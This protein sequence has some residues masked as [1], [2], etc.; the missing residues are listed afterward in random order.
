MK[1]KNSCNLVCKNVVL[2]L[3]FMHRI[4]CSHVGEALD[5]KMYETISIEPFYKKLLLLPSFFFY[6]LFEILNT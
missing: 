3:F 4:R 6:F 2:Y 5:S 1:V